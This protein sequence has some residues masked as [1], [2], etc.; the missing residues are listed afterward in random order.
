MS[1]WR[2]VPRSAVIALGGASIA[3]ALDDVVAVLRLMRQGDAA[4]PAETAVDLAGTPQAKAYA[5]PARVG[6][7]Y[8]AAGVKWT[9]HRPPVGDGLPAIVSVT[10]VNDLATGLPVGAVES[11]LLTAARTAAVSALALRTVAPAPLRR[12]AVLGAG[13]QARA[14]LGMLAELFPT[15]ESVT[16]WNRTP[17]TCAR[18]AEAARP[19]CPWPVALAGS[20][21]GAVADADAVIACTAAPAP[22]LAETV[23]RPGRIVLQ[24]GYHEV[25]FDAIDRADAV[26]VD[27]WGPFKDIS[28]KSL[29][30]MHRAGR[31]AAERVSADLARVV[32]DGWRPPPGSAVY[33]SSFGLNVFDVAL[34]ARVLRRAEAEGIGQAIDLLD[35]ADAPDLPWPMT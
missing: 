33:F 13:T 28:A 6:G 5:L 15:L 22:I 16:L 10:L 2:L 8:R 30:Q 35:G 27:L 18:L 12:V 31:F 17:T 24:V 32:V 34:A 1:P 29:F 3:A 11:A 26:V 20:I 19:R 21:D 7:A 25:P 4:M 23:M 9:A 14:H